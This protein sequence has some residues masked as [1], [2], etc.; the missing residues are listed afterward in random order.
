MNFLP[1]NKYVGILVFATIIMVA[2]IVALKVVKI[3]PD[4][5]CAGCFEFGF[6]NK[7]SSTP[8]NK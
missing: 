4:P 7:P 2:V 3:K 6:T 8:T 5:K 1:Q